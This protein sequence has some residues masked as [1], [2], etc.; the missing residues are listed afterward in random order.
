M[1]EIRRV[2][3]KAIEQEVVVEHTIACDL[4]GKK[5]R[6]PN[7]LCGTDWSGTTYNPDIVRVDREE[8]SDY[9]GG[10][11]VAVVR[12]TT[13]DICPNCFV[14]KVIPF[15]ASLGVVPRVSDRD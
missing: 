14:V 7:Q 9:A 8:R 13:F 3:K 10:N 12:R 15:F 5:S 1:S 4:C 2:E 11:G 6:R